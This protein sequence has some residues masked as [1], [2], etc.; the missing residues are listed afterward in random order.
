V[1]IERL[2]LA[3]IG[4]LRDIEPTPEPTP[5]ADEAE[6]FVFGAELP[7]FVRRYKDDL[8]IYVVRREMKVVAVGVMY[9]DPK[10]QAVRIGSIVVDHRQRGRGIGTTILRDLVSLSV[11][12]GATVCWVVHT[13]N[14]VMLS[15]SRRIQPKPDEA[16]VDD[17]YVMFVAP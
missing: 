4:R 6:R 12:D 1:S 14:E 15:C 16:S 10:F 11:N 5:W 9:P 7:N 3:E 8:Y 13:S 17:S 2:S